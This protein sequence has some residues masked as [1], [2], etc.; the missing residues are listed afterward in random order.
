LSSAVRLDY[1]RLTLTGGR[2]VGIKFEE[3]LTDFM[4][5]WKQ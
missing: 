1:A 3:A 5:I 2:L 4:E